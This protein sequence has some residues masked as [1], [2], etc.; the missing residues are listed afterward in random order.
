L[1]YE[2]TF[3]HVNTQRRIGAIS[4]PMRLQNVSAM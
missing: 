3:A 4:I 1:N 2:I